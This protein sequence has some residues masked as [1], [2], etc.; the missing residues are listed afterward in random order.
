MTE[1]RPGFGELLR[2]HRV[3]AELTQHEL[4]ER[5]GLSLRGLSD[6]E[7]GLRK[8][9]HRETAQRLAR[10]FGLDPEQQA[11][12][13]AERGTRRAVASSRPPEPNGARVQHLPSGWTPRRPGRRAHRSLR[14]PRLERTQARSWRRWL[15]R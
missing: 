12:L 13:L 9:P 5:A 1:R 11:E 14:S 3:A 6:L 10:V 2:R 8:S 15:P 4:A 7:R